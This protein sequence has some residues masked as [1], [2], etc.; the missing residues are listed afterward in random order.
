MGDRP[1]DEVTEKSRMARRAALGSFL[2]SMVEYYD[3]LIYGT[4]AAL[5]FNKVFFPA[6]NP[7]AGTLA[8]LATFG[9]GY[10][11]RPP[12]RDPVRPSRRPARP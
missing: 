10:L 6:S 9:V 3:F 12:G 4:A 8:A 7:T 5:V 11:V 2:G 1:T